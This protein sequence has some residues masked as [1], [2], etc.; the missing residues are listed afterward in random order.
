[1]HIESH[2]DTVI[3]IS[4]LAGICRLST[5]HFIRAFRCSYGL[6]PHRFIM[7]RRTERAQGLMLTTT[8]SLGQIA[9][10]C[11]LADQSHLTRLFQRFVGESPSNWRR[12]RT[13]PG[14]N[15]ASL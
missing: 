4:D 6:S 13:A 15:A 2:I 3:R 12:A 10:E 11:G 9:Q 8:A 1:M 5:S 14:A 7:R